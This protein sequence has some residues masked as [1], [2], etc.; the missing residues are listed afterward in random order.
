MGG[1]WT[2]GVGAD[3]DQDRVFDLEAKALGDSSR[4]GPQRFKQY[5]TKWRE[6]KTWY[7]YV[8]PWTIQQEFTGGKGYVQKWRLPAAVQVDAPVE[9]D[10]VSAIGANTAATTK[11]AAPEPKREEEMDDLELMASILG[12]TPNGKA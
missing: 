9:G 6:P 2:K 4:N 12:N 8:R 10:L 1:C 7:S 3:G 5:S 11:A